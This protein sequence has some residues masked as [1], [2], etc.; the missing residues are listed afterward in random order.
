MLKMEKLVYPGKN[1]YFISYKPDSL[2]CIVEDKKY[3]FPGDTNQCKN[4]D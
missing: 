1:N 4:L 2:E 3:I